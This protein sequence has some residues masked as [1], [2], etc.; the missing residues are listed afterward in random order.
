MADDADLLGQAENALRSFSLRAIAVSVWLKT[1]YTD[2][3]EHTPWSLTV[4]PEA[5]RAHELAL[6]IRQ[7]LGLPHRMAMRA[8]ATPALTAGDALGDALETLRMAGIET[9]GQFERAA[10]EARGE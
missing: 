2:A 8:V 9:G 1:P 10:R 7:H 5:R 4:G 6:E 3:P